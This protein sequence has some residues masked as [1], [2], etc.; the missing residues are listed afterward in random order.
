MNIEQKKSITASLYDKV[1]QTANELLQ[2]AKKFHIS[3][4]QSK[5]DPTYEEIAELIDDVCKI[6]V[7]LCEDV[8]EPELGAK[9]FEYCAYV[10]NMAIAIKEGDETALERYVEELDRKSFL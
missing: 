3:Y 9:A 1:L 10:K 2:S 7:V 5:S 4:L 8:D 6:I